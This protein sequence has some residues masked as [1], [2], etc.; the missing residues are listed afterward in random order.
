[1]L[2]L[3]WGC[4]QTIDAPCTAD[5]GYDGASDDAV[6]ALDHA[7]CARRLVGLE[8]GSLHPA[9]DEASQAHADYM[10]THANLDH[11][12]VDGNAGFTGVWV[13]DRLEAAGYALEPGTSWSEVVA[14]GEGPTGSVDRWLNSVYHRIPFTMPSW[15]AVGFGQADVYSSMT[16]VASYPAG[17]RVAVLYPGD[18]QTDVPWSFDS[19]T[20]FPDPA[21]DQ[22]LVGPPITVTVG[23]AVVTGSEA[24]PH[25][26]ELL[27]ARLEG[28]EGELELAIL[29]PDED[30][31]LSFAVAA[32]PV[33]PLEPLTD[34]EVEMVVRFEGGEETLT[35]AFTTA[36]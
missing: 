34:Y 7:N 23:E 5:V 22:G 28:P 31:F 25:G 18:G 11:Q 24:N 26:L 8:P 19:D 1:M 36:E 33:S 21:P 6:A 30:E 2:T 14:E 15:I 9:V 3:L 16:F 17:R 27:S 13:W 4:A 29:V 35:G 32:I 10:A 20:E 12:E